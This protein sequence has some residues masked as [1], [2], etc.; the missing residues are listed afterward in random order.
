M[1]PKNETCPAC[2]SPKLWHM[3]TTIEGNKC[4]VL[5]SCLDCNTT[6]RE[7]HKL[8]YQSTEVVKQS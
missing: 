1:Q 2:N 4:I 3:S 8:E 5:F 7:I 6:F